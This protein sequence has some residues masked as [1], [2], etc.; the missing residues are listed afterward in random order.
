LRSG[1]F[2]GTARS[3]AAGLPLPQVNISSSFWKRSCRTES[4]IFASCVFTVIM[5]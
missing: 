1:A 4:R 5:N 3:S 2:R